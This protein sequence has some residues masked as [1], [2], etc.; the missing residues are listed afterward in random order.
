MLIHFRI[1]H[2]TGAIIIWDLYSVRCECWEAIFKYGIDHRR[3]YT[4]I[5]LMDSICLKMDWVLRVKER[6]VFQGRFAFPSSFFSTV[7]MLVF[8]QGG[9]GCTPL[10]LY[11]HPIWTFLSIFTTNLPGRQKTSFKTTFKSFKAGPGKQIFSLSIDTKRF[12]ETFK[13]P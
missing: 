12:S 11:F 13:I 7:S 2:H 3:C 8:F 9:A 4:S 5:K 6:L 1:I 10:P